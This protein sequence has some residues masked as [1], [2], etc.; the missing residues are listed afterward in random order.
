[1]RFLS[2]KNALRLLAVSLLLAS[3]GTS[4][5]D[6]ALRRVQQSL[7]DQG[8]YYGAIDGSPGD[9]T[10]Q[11]IRRYQI[12][13]GLG[14]TGQ[15]NDETRNSIARTGANTAAAAQG[16]SRSAPAPRNPPVTANSSPSPAAAANEPD[17]RLAPRQTVRPPAATNRGTING[18]DEARD[19]ADAPEPAPPYR[20]GAQNRPDLRAY[21]PQGG[22]GNPPPARF[23]SAPSATLMD[24][25]ER[26]PYEFAPPPVQSDLL[27]RVQS[28][29]NRAGFYDGAAD[30][31][32]G[33]RTSEA[34][35]NFQE[36]N[37][38]RRTGRL[39]ISTLEVLRILP[40]RRQYADPRGY[41]YQH[42]GVYEGRIVQ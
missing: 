32:P 20:N 9:E 7:R 33:Q 35:V 34:I 38:L 25:F 2:S 27:R 19:D 37:R 22:L 39:D 8:F 31:L 3:A 41:P 4:R 15:L 40:E 24:L 18:D 17:Y 11:A 26:T 14:V 30:G 42:G 1:M 29:L 23:G 21:P 6:E 28:Q 5:A 16:T 10:T 36:V 13:N 12:R